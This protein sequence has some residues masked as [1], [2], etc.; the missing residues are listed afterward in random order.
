MNKH[1]R[2]LCATVEVRARYETLRCTVGHAIQ[3]WANGGRTWTMSHQW[4]DSR[5]GLGGG[6]CIH[7]GKTLKEVR[8]RINPKTGKPVRKAGGL[9]REIANTA[10]DVPPIRFLGA[11]A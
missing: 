1:P 2:N 4:T 9:A 11:S 3:P 7:C 8:V 6:T 10:V 5:G